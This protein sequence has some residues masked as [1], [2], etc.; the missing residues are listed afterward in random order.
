MKFFDHFTRP[1]QHYSTTSYENRLVAETEETEHNE[2]SK[3][4]TLFADSFGHHVQ[5]NLDTPPDITLQLE[6]TRRF[7]TNDSLTSFFLDKLYQPPNIYLSQNTHPRPADKRSF[8]YFLRSISDSPRTRLTSDGDTEGSNLITFLVGDVGTGKTLLL[9]KAI[10]DLKKRERERSVDEKVDQ[11]LLP[12][13][14]DFETEMKGNGGQLIDIDDGFYGKLA[15]AIVRSV[16]QTHYAR[17]RA[18]NIS[19]A[20]NATSV[21]KLTLLISLVR[22][23]H[24]NNL[25]IL[26]ILDNL[27]GYHYHYSKYA[28]F[29][30]YHRQQVNSIQRNITGLTTALSHGEQLGMLG[31]SVVLA[32]R[33]YVYQDCLH[34]R[35][36][37]TSAEFSGAVFQLDDADE[38]KVVTMRLKLFEEAIRIIESNP[39][40]R[41]FGEDY[42][43]T[44]GRL[45]V[46]FGI[47]EAT[48]PGA[49]KPVSA[50]A[51]HTL[52]LLCRHGNRDLVAFL[53]N[54][55]LDHREESALIER[56]FWDKPHTLVLLYIADLCERYTQK[57]GHFPN[58][59]LVDALVLRDPDFP[60]AHL[61]HV[62]TY[63]MKYFLLS[64]VSSQPDGIANTNQLRR[65]FVESGGYEDGLV[66]LALGSLSMSRESRCLEPEPGEKTIPSRIAMTTRGKFLVSEWGGYQAPFCFSFTYLQLVVDDYLMSYPKCIWKQIYT[67]DA[68][69]EYLFADAS[70]YGRMNRQYL[71]D[72]T[73]CVLA[74]LCLLKESLQFERRR[75]PKLFKE[76]EAISKNIVPDFDVIENVM[77]QQY[78]RILAPLQ[79]SEK[80]LS[81]LK[82]FSQELKKDSFDMKKTFNNY[83]ENPVHV[84]D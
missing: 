71:L 54:L 28:F 19:V 52:R 50:G 37:E 66:R 73:R 79:D 7:I 68:N 44:L 47:Q 57:H 43:K 45:R 76:L 78:Q 34:T 60:N 55:R 18:T 5:F 26:L 15:S 22:F 53:S 21:T 72:K 62:H 8:D 39:K 77:F 1:D 58:I 61:P 75:R 16:E 11:L 65:I 32:A 83:F 10:R 70:I 46:L 67:K 69:L 59:F 64:Y 35:A 80:I 14:F 31:L 29:P 17:I 20:A 49:A 24:K 74:F 82:E 33:R 63:W 38:L 36:P 84:E 42:K 56:F 23:L 41:K 30:E 13:Y 40:L 51:M 4:Q 25:R 9:C 2:S 48:Q 6:N 81:D 27:D 12:V 3:Y